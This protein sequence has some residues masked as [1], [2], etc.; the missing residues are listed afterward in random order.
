[1]NGG[2]VKPTTVE[3]NIELLLQVDLVP[4]VTPPPPTN[5]EGNGGGKPPPPPPPKKKA[6]LKPC[7]CKKISITLDPTLLKKRQLSPDKR[8]FGV[9][10]VWCM[11]C[12]Q[13]NGGCT[14]VLNFRP[15][16]IRAGSLPKTTGLKLNIST[17]SF[18]CKTACQTSTTGRFEIKMT[19]P[20]Q[21]NRLFGRTLAFTITT[22][23]S[24]VT[25]KYK[26]NVFVDQSGRLHS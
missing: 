4:P 19:S 9:G 7:K 18:V 1:M 5:N 15:P 13:G 26:V 23:C 20:E 3:T 14:A 10:F 8:N 12:S 11:S 22:K 24:G 6:K 17:I 16:T 2:I 21:L 25:L